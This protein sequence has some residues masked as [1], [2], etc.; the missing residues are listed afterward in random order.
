MD[1]DDDENEDRDRNDG[2]TAD[3]IDAALLLALVLLN[4]RTGATEIPTVAS[5]G[6]ARSGQ[7][8]ELRLDIGTEKVTADDDNDERAILSDTCNRYLQR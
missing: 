5:G 1:D 6:R 8:M 4:A 3:D 2:A 7:L